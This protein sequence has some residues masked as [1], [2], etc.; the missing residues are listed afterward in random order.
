MITH[1]AVLA[2]AGL[3]FWWLS[4]YDAKVTGG[5]KRQDYIRRAVRCGITLLLVGML[6]GLPGAVT[7]HAD[8][9]LDWRDAGPDLVRL[10]C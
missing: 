10:Y 5:N 4:G 6:L 1:L 3:A 7:G 9:A 8:V 2:F